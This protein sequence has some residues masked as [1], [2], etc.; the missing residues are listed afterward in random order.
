MDDPLSPHALQKS[1]PGPWKDLLL[2]FI[3]DFDLLSGDMQMSLIAR[4]HQLGAVVAAE[5]L[6]GQMQAIPGK[7][8]T[9][10]RIGLHELIRSRAGGP[11]TT[12]FFT[13][14]VRAATADEA[15]EDSGT[16]TVT[17]KS[18]SSRD[19]SSNYR[20]STSGSV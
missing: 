19:S 9:P 18:T 17:D 16:E 11:Q 10:D 13:G 12:T 1:V 6:W 5:T 14:T 7:R 8:D 3:G 2:G 15:Q 20:S 4:L